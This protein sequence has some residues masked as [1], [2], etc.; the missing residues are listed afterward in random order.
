MTSTSAPAGLTA[1]MIAALT[2][3][4]RRDVRRDGNPWGVPDKLAAELLEAGLIEAAVAHDPRNPNTWRVW[5]IMA[6]GRAALAAADGGG[7]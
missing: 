6:S 1:E 3:T 5:R 7:E 2:I 4:S